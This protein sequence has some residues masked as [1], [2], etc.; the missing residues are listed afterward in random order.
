M[1]LS[2]IWP[3]LGQ[4]Y[5]GRRRPALLFAV[6]ALLLLLLLLWEARDGAEILAAR[7]LLVPTM[8]FL[9]VLAT[10][11]LAI[12]R[13]ASMAAAFLDVRVAVPA[14]SVRS[15]RRPLWYQQPRRTALTFGVLAA[16]VIA[17]HG[18]VAW[19]GMA[20]LNSLSQVYVSGGPQPTPGPGQTQGD[21]G[22][23][24]TPYATPEP[25][26]RINVLLIGSDGGLGYDHSLTDSLIVVTVD[27]VG[28]VV[29]MLSLPRDI[30]R[31][32]LYS[33]GIYDGKI[34]SLASYAVAHPAKFPDGGFGTLTREVG[35]LIG[36]PVHYYSYVNLAGFKA[37]IDA[38]GGVDIV[39][40]KQI[41][42]PG[43]QFPDGAR[44]FVLSPG[45]HHLNGRL[46]LA[47]V[48]SRNGPGDNDFTRARRQQELLTALRADLLEPN[49]LAH[50]PTILD[51]L[52]K[53]VQ[54][55]FP[56]EKVPDLIQL[57]QQ[58]PETAITHYVLGP[59][60]ARSPAVSTGTYELII[61]ESKFAALS[62]RLFGSSSRYAT[63]GPS[64][65]P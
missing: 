41:T 24:P 6:P 40:P 14:T 46:A 60:Y 17:M 33:G 47:Y 8:S 9:L 38:V 19:T 35:Y 43:Y 10:L 26:G 48:R 50:L 58:I 44:G 55:D 18:A 4:L 57:A 29:D 64:T 25:G 3:G 28:K 31:F 52:A 20:F 39:N 62:I 7:L 2:F 32:P 5:L 23:L 36:A 45:P 27:P 49:N 53:T 65:S 15:A 51:A 54:T 56:A 1:L 22:T 61:D 63:P 11:L 13:L 30:S 42:D 59:P 12:W 16:L 37:V 34:N 21:L